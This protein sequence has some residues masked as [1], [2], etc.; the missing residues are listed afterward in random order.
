MAKATDGEGRVQ[1]QIEWNY[2]GKN[3]D[4]IVPVDVE[5]A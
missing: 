3:F 5:I 2:L 4:G 1:P